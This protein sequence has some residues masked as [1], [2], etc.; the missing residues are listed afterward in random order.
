MNSTSG[1]ISRRRMLQTSGVALAGLGLIGPTDYSN[2]R[3]QFVNERE[4]LMS[5]NAAK[6]KPT[7]VLIHGAFA[8]GSSWNDVMSTLIGQGY[9]VVA[10]SNPLR[11]VKGD[12]DYT[13]SIL[14]SIDGPLVL[15]GHS[16]GGLIISNVA[17]GNRNVQALVYV[18]GYAPEAGESAGD[19]SG[20]FP[21]GTLGPTLAPPIPLAD[22]TNDLLIDQSKF[23]SQFCEDV[24]EPQAKRMAASQR[25]CVDVALSEGSGEPAWKTIPSWFVFGELDKNIPA[26]AHH[27][28]AKRAKARETVEVKGAS[29]ALSVSYADTVADVILRAAKHAK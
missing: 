1:H 24:P 20:R 18:A 16:Y 11:S 25:P 6:S 13:A 4:N 29:H 2:P 21:G 7:I 3:H 28:M 5:N 9:P 10:P 14:N 12:S 22:G 27:F 17:T 8:D 19:L 26:A 15:V 23:R